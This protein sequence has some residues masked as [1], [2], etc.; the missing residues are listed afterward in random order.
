MAQTSQ[1]EES[2]LA[3]LIGQCEHPL[4]LQFVFDQK[5]QIYTVTACYEKIFPAIIRC[6]TAP[7]NLTQ[8]A[9]S[10]IKQFNPKDKNAKAT[11]QKLKDGTN[12][13]RPVTKAKKSKPQKSS[14]IAKSLI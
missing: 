2:I 11:K 1:S 8:A 3:E 4:K 9:I 6:E 10:V 12:K 14:R 7:V 5:S 13:V